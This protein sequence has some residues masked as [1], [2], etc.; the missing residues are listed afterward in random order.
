M[1]LGFHQK[2]MFSPVEFSFFFVRLWS[3]LVFPTA[4]FLYYHFQSSVCGEW[5]DLSAA[6]ATFRPCRGLTLGKTKHALMISSPNQSLLV[7][8]T[9]S[10]PHQREK[11]WGREAGCSDRERVQRETH[12][13]RWG[14]RERSWMKMGHRE[15][16]TRWNRKEG[17]GE[18]GET[19]RG[20][21]DTLEGKGLTRKKE[22]NGCTAKNRRGDKYMKGRGAKMMKT[23]REKQTRVKIARGKQGN[24]RIFEN[25]VSHKDGSCWMQKK[26]EEQMN[27]LN[28]C[29]HT[30]I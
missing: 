23:C 12:K 1:K 24:E 27:M 9:G 8:T 13:G 6:A 22:W 5:N 4:P 26:K 10:L 14:D 7:Q 17:K 30:S 19:R 25:E 2:K 15:R 28:M 29:T 16:N 11:G 18:D 21:S 20:N 3:C